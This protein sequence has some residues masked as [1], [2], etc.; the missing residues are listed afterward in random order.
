MAEVSVLVP[1]RGGC[2]H[3]KAVWQW[4]QDSYQLEH[5]DW[6]IIEGTCPPGPWV[7][8]LALRD[9]ADR[10]DGDVF[11]IADADVF[12]DDLHPAIEQVAAHGWAIPHRLVHR[13]SEASTTRVLNGAG[14]H[15]LPLSTDNPQDRRPYR[16]LECGGIF[17]ITR[18]AFRT[19]L[20]DPRF[21]GW[22]Q[23]DQSL[24]TAYR[25]LVGPPW[26]GTADLVHLWHP[27]QPRRTRTQGSARNMKLYRRYH[28]A[29]RDPDAMRALLEEVTPCRTPST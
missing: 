19:A 21:E 7:K 12:V 18:D 3:R 1:F 8:A 13:L 16:G 29:R 6:Q 14:W 5:P 22:G 26:R 23:D 9:A 17:V 20:P 25:C 10:A 27:S 24:A 2:E 15:G 28:A 11:V 4:L